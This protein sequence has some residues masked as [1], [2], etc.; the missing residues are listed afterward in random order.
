MT[1][2]LLTGSAVDGVLAVMSYFANPTAS[3]CSNCN[4][5][6]ERPVSLP[7]ECGVNKFNIQIVSGGRCIHFMKETGPNA[8]T[9]KT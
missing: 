7:D 5:F 4:W 3:I 8:K 6:V 1:R 2:Q 9:S